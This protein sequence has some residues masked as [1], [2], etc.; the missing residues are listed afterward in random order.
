MM[1]FAPPGYLDVEHPGVWTLSANNLS[2]QPV[3]DDFTEVLVSPDGSWLFQIEESNKSEAVFYNMMTSETIRLEFS[4]TSSLFSESRWLSDGRVRHEIVIERTEGVGEVR[5][6]FLFDPNSQQVERFEME[7][8]LPEYTFD[9]SDV[10]RGI[11]SGYDKLDPTDQLVLYTARRSSDNQVEIRL[12]NLQTGEVL[13]HQESRSIPSLTPEWN[14]TGD[15]ILFRLSEI[16]ED[17]EFAWHK[18]I[19]LNRNGEEQPLPPQPFPETDEHMIT[20]LTQSPDKR[21]I[22]YS[23]FDFS[24]QITRGFIVDT[25]TSEIREICDPGTTFVTGFQGKVTGIWLDNNRFVYR[26]LIT[27]DSQQ[28]HSL[29]VLDIPTWTTQT[30]FEPDPGYGVNIFGW[31]P[32]EFS[33]P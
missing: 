24:T 10:E 18:I 19:R 13:W 17:T 2:P 6:V 16:I 30:V 1:S 29:R 33:E 12:I 28:T 22:F 3:Y 8:D 4:P 5:E 26:I 15:S 25:T 21:F 14:T 31:T 20:G 7:L 9:V 27:K 11:A 23:V 32:I